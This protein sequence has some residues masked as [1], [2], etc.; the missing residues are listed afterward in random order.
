MCKSWSYEEGTACN[1][2]V[3]EKGAEGD[4]N[5]SEGENDLSLKKIK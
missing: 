1:G 5:N 2:G 3:R 4:F